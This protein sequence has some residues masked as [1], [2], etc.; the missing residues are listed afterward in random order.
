MSQWS[1]QNLCTRFFGPAQSFFG[2]CTNFRTPENFC[3]LKFSESEK[4]PAQTIFSDSGNFVLWKSFVRKN[5]IFPWILAGHPAV[6]EPSG[7]EKRR[8]KRRGGVKKNC[9]LDLD[10]EQ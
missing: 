3:V 5:T 2:R 1:E 8:E 9:F 6:L 7:F 4:I 10:L